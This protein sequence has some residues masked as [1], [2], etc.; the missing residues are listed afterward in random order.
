[1]DN[2]RINQ[3][4]GVPQ[5]GIAGPQKVDNG[6]KADFAQMMN[7]KR[8]LA[9]NEQ[10]AAKPDGPKKGKRGVDPAKAAEDAQA[11]EIAQT[12]FNRNLMSMKVDVSVKIDGY[13]E[14]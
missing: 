14:E 11:M 4:S 9:A 13:S 2:L 5:A 10:T 7:D 1:M 8:D 3:R 6:K 12:M